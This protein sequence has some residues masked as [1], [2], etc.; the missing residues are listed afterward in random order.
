MSLTQLPLPPTPP[1]VRSATRDS[2]SCLFVARRS[3]PPSLSPSVNSWNRLEKDRE[4]SPS[5]LSP[6]L[7]VRSF[8]PA[9]ICNCQRQCSV[10]VFALF[11]LLSLLCSCRS[12]AVATATAAAAVSLVET[13]FSAFFYRDFYSCLSSSLPAS[14]ATLFSHS[15][16]RVSVSAP[17]LMLNAVCES[18]W[19]RRR[20]RQQN[21]D[22]Y[23]STCSLFVVPQRHFFFLL[24][25][26]SHSLFLFLVRL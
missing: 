2:C 10:V 1:R 5:C 25:V 7:S 26:F 9:Y 12:V 18:G 16:T 3:I 15:L 21:M 19:R 6:C 22:R 13:C 4:N 8:H 20:C 14:L 23:A 24:F 11:P 17:C